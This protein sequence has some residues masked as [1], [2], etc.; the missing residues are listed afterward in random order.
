M[1]SSSTCSKWKMP[2]FDE[3]VWKKSEITRKNWPVFRERTQKDWP[4]LRETTWKDLPELSE[5]TRKD[6]PEFC[7]SKRSQG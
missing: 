1:I 4:V 2:L 6:L 7:D 3:I 5:T